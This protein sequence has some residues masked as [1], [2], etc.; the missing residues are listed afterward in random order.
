[1]DEGRRIVPVFRDNP[2]DYQLFI[3]IWLGQPLQISIDYLNKSIYSLKMALSNGLCKEQYGVQ[4]L[5]V[6]YKQLFST[7]LQK[8][9]NHLRL[10]VLFN[11]R[12]SK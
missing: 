12:S 11:I 4:L 9:C 5:Y 3:I 1:M 2:S 10:E 7:K 6:F 8:A